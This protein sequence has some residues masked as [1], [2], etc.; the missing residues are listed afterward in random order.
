MAQLNNNKDTS[1]LQGSCLQH[2]CPFVSQ[3]H[4]GYPETQVYLIS[5]SHVSRIDGSD[6]NSSNPV[7]RRLAFS[8]GPQD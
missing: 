2:G 8:K 4:L 3:G 7:F 1:Y 5:R 6:N